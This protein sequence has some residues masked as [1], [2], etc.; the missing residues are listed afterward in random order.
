M[1]DGITMEVHGLRELEQKLRGLGPKLR[2]RAVRS[3]LNAGAQVIKKEAIALAPVDTGRLADKA[4]YVTRV[5]EE[6]TLTKEVY[7]VAVRHGRKEAQKDRD[8][9]YWKF[10]EFG[11]KFLA[12]RPFLVPAFESKKQEAFEK[13]K[14][15]LRERIEALAKEKR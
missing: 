15:K 5:R 8:A 14:Q 12:A 9:F 3:A 11:T 1:P 6:Q 7:A 13:I 4:I 10:L 2:E